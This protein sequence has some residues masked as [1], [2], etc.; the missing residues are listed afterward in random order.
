MLFDKN[1]NCGTYFE[2][3]ASRYEINKDIIEISLGHKTNDEVSQVLRK[4]IVAGALHGKQ[5][6][7]DIGKLKGNI[8][9][10]QP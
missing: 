9:A 6:V 8:L 4:A 7:F 5:I 1:G 10:H 3:K 2:Y